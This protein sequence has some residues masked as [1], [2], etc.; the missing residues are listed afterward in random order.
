MVSR[1]NRTKLKVV[2]VRLAT[3]SSSSS[4][5]KAASSLLKSMNISLGL[6]KSLTEGEGIDD[7]TDFKSLLKKSG[8]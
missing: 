3:A 6:P 7:K 5:S 4:L 8:D 1:H 2:I